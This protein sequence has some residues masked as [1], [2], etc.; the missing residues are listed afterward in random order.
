M[1][2][3]RRRRWGFALA[4]MVMIGLTTFLPVFVQGVMQQSPLIGGF[5]LSAMVLGW[6]IGAT[7]GVRVGL[8]RFGV[9]AMRG[10]AAY[11]SR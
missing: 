6:P 11:S 5:A 10:S 3:D 7:V 8:R 9:R 2:A 4:G 1:P